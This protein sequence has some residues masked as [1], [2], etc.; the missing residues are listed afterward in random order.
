MNNKSIVLSLASLAAFVVGANQVAHAQFHFPPVPPTLPPGAPPVTVWQHS[1]PD[2]QFDSINRDVK[3]RTLDKIVSLEWRYRS[4]D[5]PNAITVVDH[6]SEVYATR[7]WPTY[8]I[9]ADSYHL[10]VA[11]QSTSGATILERWSFAT[12][13]GIGTPAPSVVTYYS[14]C[15]SQP[16]Y[17]WTLPP[18]VQVDQVLS[19]PAG[20][21]Q[22]LVR[23]LFPNLKTANK[24]YVYYAT[25]REVYSVDFHTQAQ[26]LVA[27]PS[28]TTGS[29]QVAS[30][31]QNY[32]RFWSA[33][34]TNRGYCYFFCP[35]YLASDTPTG[36][37]ALVDSDRDGFIDTALVISANDWVTGAWWDATNIIPPNH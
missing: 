3:C 22:G 33:D 18:R 13:S 35:F 5:V 7:Y 30:L 28:G 14:E 27:S 6:N 29:L 15:S 4:P 1:V 16:H 37:L 21:S 25:S 31:T 26:T 36:C 24:L 11:G 32:G 34:Y 12:Q 2:T 20:S 10:C 23:A 9:P 19:L 8:V 17:A